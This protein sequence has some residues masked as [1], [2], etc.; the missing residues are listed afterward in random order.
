MIPPVL[1]TPPAAVVSPA[2]AKAQ[3]YALSALSDAQVEVLI[4]GAT[5]SLDGPNGLLKKC[6]GLQTWRQAF[7]ERAAMYRLP[8]LGNVVVTGAFNYLVALPAEAYTIRSDALGVYV[9]TSDDVTHVE[10]TAGSSTVPQNIKLAIILIAADIHAKVSEQGNLRSFEAYQA[11]T[12][13]Y[14]NPEVMSAATMQTVRA[15][16]GRRVGIVYA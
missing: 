1:V 13:Q 4:A 15:L 8:D 9:T 14:S 6:I 12:E 11:Y 5:A 10:F 2:E 3:S 7:D 16:L